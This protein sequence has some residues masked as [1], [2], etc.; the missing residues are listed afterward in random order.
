[1]RQ[2]E[3]D[4]VTQDR[5]DH[6]EIS[7]NYGVLLT[8]ENEKSKIDRNFNRG[9][10]NLRNKHGYKRNSTKSRSSNSVYYFLDTTEA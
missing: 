6:V 2:L 8:I 10:M 4:H 5:E 1:M 9:I 7:G 3:T